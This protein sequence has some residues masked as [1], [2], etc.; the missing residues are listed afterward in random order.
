MDIVYYNCD[1]RLAVLHMITI[2]QYF[3]SHVS[4]DKLHLPRPDVVCIGHRDRRL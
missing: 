4:S 1:P 3:V 2:F